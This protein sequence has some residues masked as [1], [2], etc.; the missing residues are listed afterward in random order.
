MKSTVFWVVS[1]CSSEKA[2][3]FKGTYHIHLQVGLCL[4]LAS[5]IILLSLFFGP[6]YGGDM[7]LWI[8]ASLQTTVFQPRRQ[9]Y[10]QFLQ[11][12]PQIKHKIT[13]FFNVMQHRLVDRF[14]WN[15][16]TRLPD[17]LVSHQMTVILIILSAM[18]T[19]SL[20]WIIFRWKY[21]NMIVQWMKSANLPV[22]TEIL[23]IRH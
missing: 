22:V 16:G 4:L 12:K 6:E 10:S 21:V 14:L 1:P 8:V 23:F 13:V 9:Y 19:S 15:V 2:Q 7:F 5:A 18:S 11:S 17:Y 20:I 3:C